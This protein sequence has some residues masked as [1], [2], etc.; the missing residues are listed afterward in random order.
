MPNKSDRSDEDLENELRKDA[1]A[2]EEAHDPIG[3]GLDPEQGRAVEEMAKNRS[4][5]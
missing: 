1:K 4:R 5:A 2:A 3:L